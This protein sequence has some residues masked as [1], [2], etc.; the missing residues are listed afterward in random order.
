MSTSTQFRPEIQGL[1]GIAALLV[2]TYHIWFAKVSGGV[3]VFF[4]VSG[5]LITHSLLNRLAA[6]R[7][8]RPGHFLWDLY[9]RL[10]PPALLVVAMTAIGSRLF[11]PHADWPFNISEAISAAFFV[12]NWHLAFNAVDYL[13]RTSDPRPFQH[14]WALSVQWQFYLLWSLIFLLVHRA[15]KGQFRRVLASSFAVLFVVSL[16]V[17]VVQTAHN[18]PFAY[19]NTA[20]RIWEF[21]AGALFAMYQ[22]RWPVPKTLGVVLGWSGLAAIVVCGA[23]LP[24]STSFPGFGAL[25]PVTGA[26]LILAHGSS[27][28][29]ASVRRFLS[30]GPLAAFGRV[31][32]YFYLWHWP[33]VVL[34]L[35]YTLQPRASVVDGLGIMALALLLSVVTHVLMRVPSIVPQRTWSGRSA[36]ALT[37]TTLCLCVLWRAEALEAKSTQ[38]AMPTPPAST[39]PGALSVGRAVASQP[40]FPGSFRVRSDFPAAYKEG[41][42]QTTTGTEVI[43]CT[44]GDAGAR[45]TIAA[46]G[47][48]HI[49]HWLPALDLA[50]REYGW[51]VLL[52]VKDDCRLHVRSTGSSDAAAASCDVWNARLPAVVHRLAPDFL[53]VGATVHDG[54]RETVPD[55]YAEAWRRLMPDASHVVAVRSTPRFPFDVPDCVDLHGGDSPKCRVPV[56]I[57]LGRPESDLKRAVKGAG[58]EFL[59]LTRFFCGES[60][61]YPVVGNIVVYRDHDHLTPTYVATMKE[62]LADA[63]RARISAGST[64]MISSHPA[65]PAPRCTAAD[66]TAC[67]RPSP[68][69]PEQ[70]SGN[71]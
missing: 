23:V 46:I 44:Y 50:G 29:P 45:M 21:A 30:W 40:P 60:E 59:D 57:A 33:L 13:N 39:H 58:A 22:S 70:A 15:A 49:T 51:R 8:V 11:L 68:G 3:D 66:A 34:W 16:T 37:L 55:E 56:A 18:Q 64:A 2:A 65:R 62:P 69:K 47:N 10:G 26:I 6:D 7:R 41:C 14:Y 5:F 42:S 17:S 19:F 9:C 54:D 25:L 24:V 67:A 1:R 12:N 31:S 38:M 28:H 63:L 20:A 61:C 35:S 4:V 71:S 52:I 48:S 27:D 32:Y 53:F 36:V 43:V